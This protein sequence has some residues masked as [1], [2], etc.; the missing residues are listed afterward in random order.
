MAANPPPNV[1]I[2]GAGLGALFLAI[3]LEKAGIPYHIYEKAATVKPLG[4]I[5]VLNASIIPAFD[6]LGLLEDLKKF[7]YP[8][9][10]VD[11]LRE[12]MSRLGT[13]DYSC[14]ETE[15]GYPS[16]VF[17][18][19]DLYDLLLSKVPTEKISFNQQIVDIRQDEQ[20]VAIITSNKE[21]FRGD[22]LVGA[23]GVRSTVRQLLYNQMLD[24][25]M[26]LPVSDTNGKLRVD[27]ICIV[28][29]TEP[30]DPEK[31]PELKDN[32]CHYVDI[33]G[34]NKTHCSVDAKADEDLDA[35]QKARLDPAWR[36]RVINDA[37]NLPIMNVGDGQRTL[38]D[39][40]RA[41]LPS[42][43]SIV[44]IEEKLFE[45]WYHGR[46]VMIGDAI[47]KM[48]PSSGQGC[49][50][51]MQDAIVLGNILYDIS[52][53]AKPVN[54]T[55]ITEAFQEYRKQRFPYA[56]YHV[57]DAHL[58][59]RIVLGKKWVEKLL[60]NLV[61]RFPKWLMTYMVLKAARY[62]P[63]VAFMP[64]VPNPRI[65]VIP[66]VSSKRY[67]VHQASKEKEAAGP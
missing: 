65:T 20:G 1:L 18:R 15:A 9:Q 24:K 21:V 47:H 60:R 38:G 12:D 10:E 31:F 48:H 39:L 37:S 13:I 57:E 17:Q 64:L 34:D 36:E 54:A 6:Q 16:Y 4:S 50:N 32:R 63:Q 66:Q 30:L 8:L 11:I 33:I 62:R 67:M 41:T 55:A 52:D 49:V 25:G 19:P 2:V 3:V 23:D 59:A 42:R 27:Y 40:I 35:L 45:T 29:V 28:G 44:L 46:T 5:L 26:E 58:F 53:G 43:L 22:I 51:A 14:S 56:K 61:V 7:S